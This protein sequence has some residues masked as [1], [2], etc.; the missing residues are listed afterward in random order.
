MRRVLQPNT[1]S[2][3][4]A[5]AVMVTGET[6]EDFYQF[7]GH[8]GSAIDTQHPF[9]DGRRG[10]RLDEVA[11]YLAKRGYLLGGPVGHPYC[12]GTLS[13]LIVKGRTYRHAVVWTG[14]RVIDPNPEKPFWMGLRQYQVLEIWP[15]NKVE[16]R[17]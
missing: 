14:F 16:V 7:C 11:G 9:A 15:V 8:D 4:A 13:I 12:F 3:F 2:C 10:F 6:L 5:A 1:W 17:V